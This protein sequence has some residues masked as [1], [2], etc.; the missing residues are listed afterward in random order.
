MKDSNDTVQLI[1]PK[2]SMPSQ[3]E[4][5]SEIASEMRGSSILNAPPDNV[6]QLM[7]RRKK[8]PAPRVN[9]S[10]AERERSSVILRTAATFAASHGAWLAAFEVDHTAE[11]EF[12]DCSGLIG[13]GHFDRS[14][15]M[16]RKLTRIGRSSTVPT[17][18]ELWSVASVVAIVLAEGAKNGWSFEA[19]EA[20]L[21]EAFVK[22]VERSC[23]ENY[24]SEF[25]ISP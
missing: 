2:S 14:Q 13:K 20:E 10:R 6:V 17:A 24:Q 8:Q 9:L 5:A 1:P 4:P 19:S 16:M 25:Q 22:M 7:E 3:P 18:A 15:R 23:E 21:L 12:A 11:W